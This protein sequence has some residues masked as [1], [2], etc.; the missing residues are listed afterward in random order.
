[1]ESDITL[2]MIAR[3]EEEFLEK[4][5]DSVEGVAGEIVIV[6]TGST[7]GTSEIGRRRGAKVIEHEW[8]NDFSEARNVALDAASGRWI[9]VLD[10]DE[11]LGDETRKKLPGVIDSTTADGIEII[12]RSLMPETDVLKYEDTVLVRLFRNNRNYRYTMPVH[13]Q[14]RSSIEKNGGTI[15]R[16]DLLVMHYGYTRKSV[17]GNEDRAGRNLRIL[18]DAARHS[19]GN[20]YYRY[21]IG[22]TLMSMGRKDEAYR[23]LNNVLDLDYS[24]MGPAIL[25]RLFMKLSQLALDRN[26]NDTAIRYADRS[27]EFNPENG[28]S[29][30]VKAVGLLSGG[31]IGEGY[32]VLMAI[33]GNRGSSLRL[34]AQ[35]DHLIKACRQ[36]LKI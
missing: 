20:P 7:D 5:L 31:K 6:D 28:I 16:S 3:N 32:R 8:K 11:E 4:C 2:C 36:L 17:Q 25:D 14:M 27:L 33:R 10:A 35:L 30:Y 15:I 29:S 18:N 9:L 21:Q 12:V 24:G 13:E 34:D 22:V 26:D 23:E 1:M 19:P